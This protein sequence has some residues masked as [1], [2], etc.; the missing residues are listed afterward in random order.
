M[1]TGVP[2][3]RALSPAGGGPVMDRPSTSPAARPADGAAGA[4]TGQ[5]PPGAPGRTGQQ[6]QANTADA[7]FARARF[8]PH[9][10]ALRVAR[11]TL[12]GHLFFEDTTYGELA[13]LADFVA[14][15]L[16]DRGARPGDRACLFVPPG[17]QLFACAFGL[18]R[19]GLVPVLI[20]PGMGRSNLLA[21][22]ARMAPRVFIGVRRA[23]VVKRLF[24]RAFASVQLSLT[25]G[26]WFDR[27]RRAGDPAAGD[28][29]AHDLTASAP[30]DSDREA[31][32]LFTSGSTGPPKGV[33]YTHANFLAQ[34]ERLQALYRF[35]PGEV[36]LSCFPLF[37]LFCPSLGLTSVIPEV[38]PSRPARFNPARLLEVATAARATTSFGSPAIWRRLAPWCAARGRTIPGLRRVLM[39][40]APVSPEMI[41][42]LQ[43]VLP[44]RA[45]IHTP[46]GATESLPVASI[47][48]SE[49]LELAEESRQSPRRPP[50][51][52]C[53]GR[54][55]P[56]TDVRLIPIEDGTVDELPGQELPPGAVGE[57]CVRGPQV[58]RAYAAQA[59]ATAAAKIS[60]GDTFWHRMGDAALFDEAGRLWF[61]G[62]T[63][64]RLET[65]AGRML[66]VPVELCFQAHPA[67]RRCALVGVGPPGQE[68][69]VLVVEAEKGHGRAS[70]RRVLERELTDL[71]A[72]FTEEKETELGPAAVT[73]FLFRE[74][75]PVDVRHNAKL[76]RPLLKRWASERLGQRKLP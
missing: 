52:T 24:P 13:T 14:R 10:Q 74:N 59:A 45:E 18:F 62:R 56:D 35:E 60:D 66:P 71:A 50:A 12:T 51:G 47:S 9:A 22:V 75:L 63:G 37:A 19:A 25:V 40:G 28:L 20:D 46:Y 2:D 53:V 32:V 36:D 72:T 34:T 26:P 17:A 68:V 30:A 39:A 41:A 23:M 43:A 8:E 64:Q 5:A 67:V 21:C 70:A 48:G 57:V 44:A 16:L 1:H 7:L 38:N 65:T 33:S 73:R 4:A 3:Q 54:P 6:A 11:R 55:A 61:Q 15:D 31:A 42:G 27:A 29:E 49:I 76:D 58:T 69:P